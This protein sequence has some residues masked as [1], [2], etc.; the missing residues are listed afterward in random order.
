MFVLL[1]EGR[2][3]SHGV[4]FEGAPGADSS[5]ELYYLTNQII[6]NI[7]LQVNFIHYPLPFL[8]YDQSY[9]KRVRNPCC[10]VECRCSM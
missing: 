10:L 3:V 4:A 6:Q 1:T 2:L 8:H 5:D 7:E 9:E